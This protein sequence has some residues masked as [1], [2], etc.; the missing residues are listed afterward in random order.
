MASDK[1]GPYNAGSGEGRSLKEI[2]QIL[3]DVT[4]IA[5][6]EHHKPGRAIDVRISVLDSSRARTDFSW[7]NKISLLDGITTTYQ[8]MR[9]K[10]ET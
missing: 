5:I 7:E 6:E 3:R 8:W 2:V 10:R 9:S 4:K 1:T